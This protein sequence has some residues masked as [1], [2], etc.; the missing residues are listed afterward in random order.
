VHKLEKGKYRRLKPNKRGHYRIEPFG[1]DLGVWRGL[2]YNEMAPWLRW[3]DTKGKLLPIDQER[4]EIERRRA[5]REQRRAEQFAAKL[6]EPG[7]GRA[8]ETQQLRAEQERLRADRERIRAEQ[9]AAKLRELGV[10][11]SQ[12]GPDTASGSAKRAR[13]RQPGMTVATRV[14]IGADVGRGN[15]HMRARYSLRGRR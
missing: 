2:F 15:R 9:L 11:P 13:I 12:V 8:A 4:A 1:A 14:R 3:Y 5:D 7:V 10:D 6:R